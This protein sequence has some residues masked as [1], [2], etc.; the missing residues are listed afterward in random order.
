MSDIFISY[1]REDKGRVE[2]LAKAL[3]AKGW[4][5]WWDPQ[6][7]TGKRFDEVIEEALTEAKC[8]IVVWSTHSISSP[9]V[10]AEATE[11]ADRQVLLPVMIEDVRIPLVFRQIQTARLMDWHGSTR[12]PEF[13][14]LV[15]D[16]EA[17]LDLPATPPKTPGDSSDAIPVVRRGFFF[18]KYLGNLSLAVKILGSVGFG[19]LIWF[20]IWIFNFQFERRSPPSNLNLATPTPS[21]TSTPL[22]E[23]R[24]RNFSDLEKSITV[25]HVAFYK[26]E[27]TDKGPPESDL[28]AA[29]AHADLPQTRSFVRF[30]FAKVSRHIDFILVVRFYDLSGRM[31]GEMTKQNAYVEPDW[32]NSW[33]CTNP[34][35]DNKGSLAKGTYYAE[36]YVGEYSNKLSK[37]GA[38]RIDV[39]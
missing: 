22:P 2:I 16:I 36:V 31:R 4:S 14:K 5:V 12:D 35:L 3:Q 15:K 8:I 6:I 30:E 17:T 20:S 9:Y 19:V 11:G 34:G 21:P 27:C 33:H 10:R 1:A 26:G 29:V 25:T 37:V 23:V 39:D 18:S 28:Q 32:I 7:P 24:L 38:R 13:E